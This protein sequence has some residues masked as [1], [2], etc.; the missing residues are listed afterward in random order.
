MSLLDFAK[1]LS[2]E[3]NMPIY[4]ISDA[5]HVKK[6]GINYV[7]A[8]TVEEFVGYFKGA[9]YV[10]TNSFHGTA[11][12]VIFNRNLF[13]EFKNK[14]GRN[15]RSEGLLKTLGIDREIV[16]GNCEETEIDWADINLK[17]NELSKSSLEYL[18]SF[19]QG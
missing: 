6:D 8:P 1:K 3:K 16:D 9:E 18:S 10:V 5:P 13:V 17:I 19:A 7:V 12:S 2:K 11:F 4:Y 15:I 14:S